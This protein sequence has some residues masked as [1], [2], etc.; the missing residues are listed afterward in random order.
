MFFVF[1]CY[2]LPLGAVTLYVLNVPKRQCKITT[3]PQ[4]HKAMDV[5]SHFTETPAAMSCRRWSARRRASMAAVIYFH[6]FVLS[7]MGLLI[8][9][10]L[11]AYL[12]LAV[13]LRYTNL[14]FIIRITIFMPISR[15]FNI[16]HHPRFYID[17]LGEIIIIEHISAHVVINHAPRNLGNASACIVFE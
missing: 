10:Q 17:G 3:F 16:L 6:P 1:R 5:F 13:G 14:T 9:L 2:L 4:T 8:R 11:E 15:Q 12:I 7:G